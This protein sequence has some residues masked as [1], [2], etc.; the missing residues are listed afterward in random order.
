MTGSPSRRR[1]R[2]SASS[3]DTA[4]LQFNPAPTDPSQGSPGRL[5]SSLKKRPPSRPFN[6]VDLGQVGD[7]LR[8]RIDKL[9]EP[10]GRRLD[11]VVNVDGLMGR[12]LAGQPGPRGVEPPRPSA[13]GG[14]GLL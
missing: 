8:T 3:S 14:G 2:R 7:E 1:K 4:R 5:T 6:S 13:I 9:P 10:R 11:L 12:P